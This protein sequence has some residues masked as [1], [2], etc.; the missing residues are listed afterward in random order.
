MNKND[1]RQYNI[2]NK[3]FA[4]I[5]MLLVSSI[6]MVSTTYAWFTLSTAPEI[7]GI[8]TTVGANGNLEIALMPYSGNT[9]EITSGVGDSNKGWYNTYENGELVVGKNYTWGNLLDVSEGYS[10]D[11]IT[12]L[13]ARLDIT[14]AAQAGRNATLSD[15]PLKI[16]TYGA[17]GR[18]DAL[19]EGKVQYGAKDNAEN[20]E[21][22]G[23][24]LHD[25]TH[26]RYGVRV[27]G[28][29]STMSETALNFQSNLSAITSNKT[30]AQNTLSA[31]LATYGNTLA[32]I[33]LK[34][35]ASENDTNN[36]VAHVGDI[37]AMVADLSNAENAVEEALYNALL[38][39]ANTQAV[40][41]VAGDTLYTTV[42]EAKEAGT[43]LSTVWA[44]V[45]AYQA[46]L[47]PQFPALFEAYD[48]WE[49]I[50]TAITATQSAANALPT[51]GNVTFTQLAATLDG[52]MD[53]NYITIN[54]KPAADAKN[55]IGAILNGGGL[56]LEMNAN[57][58]IYA[59]F[60]E[61]TG[62]IGNT[63]SLPEGTEFGGMGIGGVNVNITTTT[64]P[65]AGPLLDQTRTKI[66]S[67]PVAEDTSSASVIDVSYGYALDFV[68]RT[69]AANSS[70]MLQTN[71]A[72]RVYGDSQNAATMGHGSTM[73]FDGTFDNL[74]SL[75]SMMSGI[76]VVFTDTKGSDVYGIAKVAVSDKDMILVGDLMNDTNVQTENATMEPLQLTVVEDA[77]GN[78]SLS[79][80][81]QGAADSV[82][83]EAGTD[84]VTKKHYTQFTI[85]GVKEDT[86]NGGMIVDD[87]VAEKVYRVYD[88]DIT[89]EG[90]LNLMNYEISD[91]NV[92][93]FA[94]TK[95]IQSLCLLSQ[96]VPTAISALVYLDGDY[97]DNA[98]VINSENGISTTGMLNLQFASSANLVPMTNSSLLNGVGVELPEL[99][100]GW[101]VE[102]DEMTE[103]NADYQFVLT[104]PADFAGTYTVTYQ[105]GATGEVKT[106]TAS[107]DTYTIAKEEVTDNIKIM[108]TVTPAAQ[109]PTP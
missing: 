94:G 31:S 100:E 83:V 13:P 27:M 65:G 18:I 5:A 44:S 33:A 35:A 37:K 69:N 78:V 19:A 74:Q 68:F 10:L 32:V 1:K 12:L 58:G 96:N 90:S 67:Y 30:A 49:A 60:A 8:T 15:S 81:N 16:A 59:T 51:T 62:T 43:P 20:P 40:K 105:V 108:V 36:Y 76:R 103:S 82:A 17:D 48:K 38:A 46:V 93:T 54:G 106:A 55:N 57:S 52:L 14:A 26:S 7:Q 3:L 104:K 41:T 70:L 22:A 63:I 109:E 64:T 84:E 95:S 2:R 29:S 71:A 99:P 73:S 61:L 92:L 101:S 86:V 66:A 11:E 9:S 45:T 21:V 56:T 80:T 42:K 87:A 107:G 75:A 85:K 91:A 39:L 88:Q 97:V 25:G 28:T 79:W 34:H 98:D 6:M 102:G 24:L 23:F 50:N 4:A 47:Q 77:Y 53:I 72:Q 89:L